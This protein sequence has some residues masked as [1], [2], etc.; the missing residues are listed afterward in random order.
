MAESSRKPESAE[1]VFWSWVEFWVQ[2]LGLGL[3]VVLGAFVASSAAE[4]GDY[5]AGI[6]LILAASAL[7]F[8]RLKQSFDQ[9]PRGTRRVSSGRQ[10][11][12]FDRG[13]AALCGYRRGR[14]LYCSGLA[15][16]QP[17][18]RWNSPVCFFWFSGVSRHQTGCRAHEFTLIL[19]MCG[20]RPH[21][22]RFAE[23][24]RSGYQPKSYLTSAP[25]SVIRCRSVSLHPLQVAD[26]CII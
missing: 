16:W 4:P 26:V 12:R 7:A 11:R 21:I 9:Q 14:S 10:H 1:R 22:L 13:R 6:V 19:E 25:L 18:R 17:A 5:A 8:L 15:Q 23:R 2:F 20:S 24:A 3:C